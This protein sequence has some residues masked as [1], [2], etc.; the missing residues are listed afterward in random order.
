[1]KNNTCSSTSPGSI[2]VEAVD[3]EGEQSNHVRQQRESKGEAQAS[4][5]ASVPQNGLNKGRHQVDVAWK[6]KQGC[7][8]RQNLA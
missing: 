2:H 1:M 8:N 4:G 5:Q 6:N 7:E 3:V